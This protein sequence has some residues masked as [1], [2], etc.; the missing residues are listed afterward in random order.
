MEKST[1]GNAT[2]HQTGV[3]VE[4][5]LQR[6]GRVCLR[7]LPLAAA[8]LV[9]WLGLGIG[10]VIDMDKGLENKREKGETPPN[11]Q[12]LK[13]PKAQ[14][15]WV[16]STRGSPEGQESSV[17]PGGRARSQ[18]KATQPMQTSMAAKQPPGCPVSP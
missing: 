1:R 15:W 17:G 16:S 9:R 6:A 10:G 12:G 11:T 2:A 18:G 5:R 13:P 4:G 7:V 8:V 14:G 3:V